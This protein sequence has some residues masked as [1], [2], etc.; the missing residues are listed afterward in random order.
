MV[1]GGLF[2]CHPAVFLSA[3]NAVADKKI[4]INQ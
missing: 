4:F 3:K 1:D 2:I